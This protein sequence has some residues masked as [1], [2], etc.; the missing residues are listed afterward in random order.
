MNF[1]GMHFEYDGVSSRLYDLMV[2][3]ISK[4]QDM[5]VSGKADIVTMHNRRP[6]A[7]Y[8]LNTR[9]DKGN[10]SFDLEI[11]REEPLD[12][13]EQRDVSKWLFHTRGY[14]R[15]YFDYNDDITGEWFDIVDGVPVRTYLNCV[16]T[17]PEKIEGNGGVIGYRCKAICD[18]PNAWSD[19]ISVTVEPE[20]EYYYITYTKEEAYALLQNYQVYSDLPLTNMP[21]IPAADLTAAG[22]GDYSNAGNIRILMTAEVIG[23]TYQ[24]VTEY[25]AAVFTPVQYDSSGNYKSV[26]TYSDYRTYT[27]NVLFGSKTD[28]YGLQISEVF[29]GSTASAAQLQA[30]ERAYDMHECVY[31]YQGGEYS[32]NLN[33]DSDMNEYT[34][35]SVEVITDTKMSYTDDA[36]AFR[37]WNATDDEARF[38]TMEGLTVEDTIT[39]DGEVNYTAN[40]DGDDCYEYFTSPN[41][42]RLLDGTNEIHAQGSIQ[43][44]T[45]TW[46]NRRYL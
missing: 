32:F 36:P 24:G 39:L 38:T 31:T 26:M 16:L 29:T 42:V 7:N 14:K 4:S 9:W 13:T 44:I 34:Y 40:S 8:Y 10:L 30:Y 19:E 18:A 6:A 23:R 15:M 22:W 41:F 33:I 17:E 46:K 37:I 11:V 20:L 43:S 12:P 25:R 45:I 2:A 28:T 3:S 1:Y 35:P 5:S 21:V 27:S